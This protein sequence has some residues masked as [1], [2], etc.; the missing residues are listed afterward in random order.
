M[1]ARWRRF[2]AAWLLWAGA[3][4]WACGRPACGGARRLEAQAA[5]YGQAQGPA[6]GQRAV[7]GAA[8]AGGRLLLGA[9]LHLGLPLLAALWAPWP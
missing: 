5:H 1:R 4:L 8:G 3:A 9:L 2:A 6:Q 7:G